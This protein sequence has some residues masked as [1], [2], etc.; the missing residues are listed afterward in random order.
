[1]RLI[2]VLSA[3]LLAGCPSVPPPSA[4]PVP[5]QGTLDT[6]GKKEDK[7]ESRTAA[8]VTVA[9]DN[10]DKPA[11]VKAELTVAQAGLPTP[12]AADL[13]YAR[14]RAAKGDPKVY[15]SNAASAAKAKADIDAMWSKMED[16]QKKNAE[17]MSKLHG[18]IDT[19]KKQVDEAKK[20]GQRNLYAMVAAG[21]MV[22]G[23]FAIAFGRVMIGAGLLVS[24]IC[25]GAVPFLLDSVWFIPAVGGTVLL[26]L[27]VAGV[28]VY[29]NHLKADAPQEEDKNQGG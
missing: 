12:T 13:E 15:E 19:L 25:I 5:G 4:D 16:E 7:L 29:R 11:V 18:E 1:M 20:E 27:L 2:L 26:G 14:A 9:K 17:V 6:V 21:M 28:H 22:L 10:A 24:G 23:G 3:L 8:A